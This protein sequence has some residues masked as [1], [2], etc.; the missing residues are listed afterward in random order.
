[1]SGCGARKMG[2]MRRR[3][4]DVL[5]SICLSRGCQN[6]YTVNNQSTCSLADCPDNDTVNNQSWCSLADCPNN[7]TV[8]NQSTSSLADCPNNYTVN[9]QS[10]YSLADCPNNYTVNNQS[11]CS[12][13]VNNQSTC[14]L[15]DCP[16]NYTVNNQSTYSLADRPTLRFWLCI[17][18]HPDMIIMVHWALTPN[19]WSI[20]VFKEP[21]T[22][23]SYEQFSHVMKQ[24]I[25][26]IVKRRFKHTHA[27]IRVPGAHTHTFTNLY[28]GICTLHVF[29]LIKF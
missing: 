12:Y 25:T 20:F 7:Y 18:V 11:T 26:N 29:L 10:T 23:Q 28:V 1:M 17:H 3:P 9:N 19:C 2:V 13:T 5:V 6:N 8:N 24:I 27:H 16:D 15:A 14:S 22:N 21:T 4:S